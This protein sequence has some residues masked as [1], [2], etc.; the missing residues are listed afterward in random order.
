MKYTTEGSITVRCNT[1]GEPEGL[2]AP[3]QTAVEIMVADTGCGIPGDKLE[4]IFR[5]FEQ[6]ESSQPAKSGQAGLGAFDCKDHYVLQSDSS[7][8]LGLAVVA[9]IVEQL[10]GQLRVDSNVERGS[11]F[12]FLIPLTLYDSSTDISRSTSGSRPSSN[13][14][15]VLSRN[16]SGGGSGASEIDSLVEALQSNPM[17]DAVSNR[18]PIGS[19]PPSTQSSVGSGAGASGVVPIVGATP[20]RPIRMDTFEM[21]AAYNRTRTNM[22]SP[23]ESSPRLGKLEPPPNLVPRAETPA[24]GVAKPASPERPKLRVLIVEVSITI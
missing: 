5:E 12:S 18:S 16:D 1:Y 6:V 10:G 19:R 21:D 22:S 9:R 23:S 8:G 24:K 7:L 14:R 20:L 11:Q 15:G 13:S 2:R 4:S 3:K 17:G